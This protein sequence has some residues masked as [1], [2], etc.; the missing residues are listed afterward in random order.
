MAQLEV[1]LCCW[2][3]PLSPDDELEIGQALD[4]V[5]AMMRLPSLSEPIVSAL[6]RARQLDDAGQHMKAKFQLLWLSI[7]QVR[8]GVLSLVGNDQ[9]PSQYS[10]ALLSRALKRMSQL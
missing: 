6:T 9:D 5:D 7:R 10:I 2:C 3:T 8:H 4:I 1:D